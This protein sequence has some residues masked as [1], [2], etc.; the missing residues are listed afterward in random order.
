MS[1]DD[2]TIHL[3]YED[4]AGDRK[5]HDSTQRRIAYLRFNRA[6]VIVANAELD[7]GYPF[8][9]QNQSDGLGNDDETGK[10]GWDGSLEAGPRTHRGV[11]H[12]VRPRIALDSNN[13]AYV[14]WTVKQGHRSSVSRYY[15]GLYL[16]SVTDSGRTDKYAYLGSG[17]IERADLD[18]SPDDFLHIMTTGGNKSNS[19][20]YSVLDLSSLTLIPHVGDQFFAAWA[21]SRAS[22]ITPW[23]TVFGNGNAH[24]GGTILSHP[25]G[26]ASLVFSRRSNSNVFVLNV[27]LLGKVLG[28]VGTPTVAGQTDRH[29]NR[30][31]Q[32]AW[33]SPTSIAVLM[34]TKSTDDLRLTF[35]NE[36]AFPSP[37]P[38]AIDR[39]PSVT[40][41]PDT[42][43]LLIVGQEFTYTLSASDDNTAAGDITY[44]LL[45]GPQTAMLSGTAFTW[46]PGVDEG[47]DHLVMIEVCDDR[48]N[49]NQ[50]SFVLSVEPAEAPVITSAAPLVAL[51]TVPYEYLL[52]V[53]DPNTASGDIMTFSLG[54]PTP[55]PGDMAISSG[56]LLTWTPT[57]ADIGTR[58]IQI[59]VTDSSGL[60]TLQTFALEVRAGGEAVTGPM[61]LR[62]KDSGCSGTGFR[63]TAWSLLAMAL[64]F[65][66]R[67]CRG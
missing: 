19:V 60:F 9:G 24:M 57:E 28:D 40:S 32:T 37:N 10:V 43:S 47:G 34:S 63:P 54:F 53:V 6:G 35:L 5:H 2:G 36:A 45:A 1:E 29:K 14:V 51:T 55:A 23:T 27:D 61:G 15:R 48:G 17:L 4:A 49:C 42:S 18:I 39:V 11:H 62:F 21:P 41:T 38:P 33:A 64:L 46:T 12:T 22:F 58:S 66:R 50:Q 7:P 67:R 3:V 44:E 20:N 31:R 30:Y 65:I 26:N 59:R 13:K 16:A 25:N 56:G 52:T 8:L